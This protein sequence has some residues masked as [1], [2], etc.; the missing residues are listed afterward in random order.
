VKGILLVWDCY[1]H[2]CTKM[3]IAATKAVGP[4]EFRVSF[5]INVVESEV[6]IL[7]QDGYD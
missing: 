6:G 5:N 7:V 3:A 2:M 1:H 4:D